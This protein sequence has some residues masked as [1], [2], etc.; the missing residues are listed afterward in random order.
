MKD[1]LVIGCFVPRCIVKNTEKKGKQTVLEE[2]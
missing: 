2:K 1:G